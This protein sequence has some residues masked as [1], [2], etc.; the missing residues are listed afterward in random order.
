MS[1]ICLLITF[2]LTDN[3]RMKMIGDVL[4]YL[5]Y[6]K[7]LIC[8]GKWFN[9]LKLNNFL[10][11]FFSGNISGNSNI[12]TMIFIATSDQMNRH[13]KYNSINIAAAGSL[14]SDE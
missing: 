10:I 2:Y 7:P 14:K 3:D 12:L 4:L 13:L 5:T 6:S 11:I 1:Y 9:S 8:A